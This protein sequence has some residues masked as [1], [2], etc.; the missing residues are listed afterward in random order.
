[1]FISTS[2][3]LGDVKFS[4]KNVDPLLKIISWVWTNKSTWKM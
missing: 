3:L 1:L 4:T 2:S